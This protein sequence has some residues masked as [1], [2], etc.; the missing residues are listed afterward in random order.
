MTKDIGFDTI[1][2]FA[3][4]LDVSGQ[5]APA[6]PAAS[7]SG[8]GCRSSRCVVRRRLL[9][10]TPSVQ[11]S[12]GALP[13]LYRHVPDVQAM[14]LL[15]V[16]GEYSGR[17]GHPPAGAWKTGVTNVRAG[18]S[19]VRP[20]FGR[21]RWSGAVQSVAAHYVDTMSRF[22]NEVNHP[23][24]GG[25]GELDGSHRSC[26]GQSGGAAALT[27]QGPSRPPQRLRRKVFTATCRRVERRPI[28]SRTARDSRRWASTG[29]LVDRAGVFAASRRRSSVGA[30]ALRGDVTA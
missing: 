24:G 8:S 10:F 27:R 30:E 13:P 25:A 16:I 21:S 26:R 12:T 28:S 15:L 1:D 29:R 7:A 6:H 18:A 19:T 20:G 23:A 17:S 5:G 11:R 2:I 3:D 22:S 4:P 9:D 14:N